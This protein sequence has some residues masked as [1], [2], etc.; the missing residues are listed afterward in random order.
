MKAGKLKTL[1]LWVQGHQLERSVQQ[2]V[3]SLLI[4]VHSVLSSRLIFIMVLGWSQS[5]GLH[6]VI[7]LSEKC[8]I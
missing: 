2:H 6:M 1:H 3:A 7:V 5:K 4:V 8:F